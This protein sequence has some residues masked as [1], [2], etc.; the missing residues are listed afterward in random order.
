MFSAFYSEIP[1]LYVLM[2]QHTTFQTHKTT[3]TTVV[4]ICPYFN[5]DISI[6]QT[7]RLIL[8]EETD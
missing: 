3:D 4:F 7:G 2:G 1:S 6:N 5:P 8:R